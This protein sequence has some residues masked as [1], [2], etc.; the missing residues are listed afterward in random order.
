MYNEI[1]LTLLAFDHVL[2]S[3]SGNG[4]ICRGCSSWCG[5]SGDDLNPCSG[6][7]GRPH[8]SLLSLRRV[9]I[10][11]YYC[12][13]PHDDLMWGVSLWGVCVEIPLMILQYPIS[14]IDCKPPD[15]TDL[16]NT[17]FSNRVGPSTTTY[18]SFFTI[19]CKSGSSHVQ[20]TG[21]GDLG[22]ANVV[23]CGADGLWNYG[24]F[25]CTGQCF[26]LF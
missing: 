26:N 7:D 16:P 17:I 9:L 13:V 19:T 22:G 24:T 1:R 5:Q 10:S 2:R 6:L 25:R 15:L 14:V 8:P 12:D 20:D 3:P 23:K 11:V 4:I 18:G 21:T